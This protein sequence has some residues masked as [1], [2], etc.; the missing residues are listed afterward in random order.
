MDTGDTSKSEVFFE[1]MQLLYQEE[2][3]LKSQRISWLHSLAFSAP[4][5]RFKTYESEIHPLIRLVKGEAEPKLVEDIGCGT[6]TIAKLF[7]KRYPKA[8]LRTMDVDASVKPDVTAN[9]LQPSSYKGL[10]RPDLIVSRYVYCRKLFEVE[11]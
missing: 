2:E 3:S 11:G 1:L 6:K 5:E 8:T 7:A 10:K 9:F 4:S